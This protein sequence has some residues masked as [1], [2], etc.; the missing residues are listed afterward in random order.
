MPGHDVRMMDARW[1]APALVV[2]CALAAG[3]SGAALAQAPAAA[4]TAAPGFDEIIVTLQ[5]NRVRSGEFQ[6]LRTATGDF[7]IAAED[8]A[9]LKIAA[10]PAARREHQGQAY[11]SLQAQGAAAMAFNEAELLLALELPTAQFEGTSIDLSSRPAPLPVT[12]PLTSAILNYRAAL[13]RSALSPLQLVLTTDMNVRV[14]EVLLR[15]E[16]KVETGRDAPAFARG[17]TQLIWDNRLKGRRVVAG[18]QI[19]LGGP[20]GSSITAAGIS[21]SRLFDLTPDVLRQPTASL[22]VNAASPSQ[23][24]VSVDGSTVYRTIVAPGPVNLQNLFYL[25]GARTVRVTVTDA[26]GRRQVIEQPFLFTDSVLAAG[27]HEYSYFAGRRSVLD[28]DDRWRYVQNVAQG[29]H[30]YGL[31]DSIT[32]EGSAEGSEDVAAGT[33][34]ISLR[35]DNA[36]LISV[37]GHTSLDRALARRGHGWSGRYTYLGP[38]G[39]FIIGRRQF[40]PDFRNLASTAL[41]SQL[42]A[43]TRATLSS[44]IGAWGSASVD[45]ARVRTTGSSYSSYALRTATNLNARTLLTGE[46]VRTRGDEGKDWSVNF[47]LRYEFEDQ[48]WTGATLRA[49]TGFRALDVEAGKTPGQGE[50][51]G[52][53]VGTSATETESGLQSSTFGSFNWN[54]KHATLDLNASRQLHGGDASFLEGAVSGSLVAVQGYVGATRPVPDSFALARLGVP[55]AGVE[56]FLNS[57]PQGQTNAD[58]VLLI[59]NLGA[60]GRQEVSLDD[61]QLPIQYSLRSRRVTVA[62]A[63]RSGTVVEF[64]GHSLRAVSGQAWV[65]QGGVRSPIASRAWTMRSGNTTL[66]LSTARAGEFYLEDAPPGRYTGATEWE[67]KQYSCRMDIPEFSEAVLELKDGVLCE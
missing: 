53:R 45:W 1:F 23:V 66:D 26:S 24:E 13:R 37:A 42:L 56:V 20:F 27:L 54:L 6:L 7:W 60:F 9:R 31:N 67:G 57:Q 38:S 36:G 62:P 40:T 63:F 52:Y 47:Y 29:Y 18:D 10:L 59:P 19:T 35:S 64:G 46:Y 17:P 12:P 51:I 48:K 22:T 2:G 21:L 58:G 30:R 44:R 25:G 4:V 8:L 49:G 5:V 39:A 11:Y 16:A 15:Q 61:K 14:G 32:L 43:E 65:I 28:A 50:G 41:G 34:G 3:G 55:Q 33:A